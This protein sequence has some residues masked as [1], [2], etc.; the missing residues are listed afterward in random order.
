MCRGEHNNHGTHKAAQTH[1]ATL[2]AVADEA[3]DLLEVCAVSGSFSITVS[4]RQDVIA[5]V[6]LPFVFPMPI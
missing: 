2:R 3:G 4:F 5:V 1:C 6:T